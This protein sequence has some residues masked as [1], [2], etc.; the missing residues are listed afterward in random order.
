MIHLPMTG[1]QPERRPRQAVTQI[2]L[3]VQAEQTTRSVPAEVLIP[4]HSAAETRVGRWMI[5]SAEAE[6]TR[7]AISLDRNRESYGAASVC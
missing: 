6:T 7:L 4:I 5:R 2:H 1:H 3:A